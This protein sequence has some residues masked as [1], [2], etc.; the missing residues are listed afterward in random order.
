MAPLQFTI[1]S[2]TIRGVQN[3]TGTDPT[4]RRRQHCPDCSVDRMSRGWRSDFAF[5]SDAGAVKSPD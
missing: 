3:F 1:S 4:D 2:T 5:H